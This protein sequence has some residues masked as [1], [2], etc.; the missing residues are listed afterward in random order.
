MQR[1][2][3]AVLPRGLRQSAAVVAFATL[4]GCTTLRPVAG[5]PVDWAARDARVAAL[6]DW[7]ARGR[8]AVKSDR[9]GGQGDLLWRQTGPAARLRVSGPFGAGAYE[10]RWDPQALRVTSRNGEFMREWQDAAAAEAFLGEQLGW[11]L[12][13]ASA[14]WWLL[15]LAD[16]AT[17]AS[18]EF[19]PRGELARLE[20]GGWII[21]YER[22]DATAGLEMPVRLTLQSPRARLRVVIDR[23]CL[24]PACLEGPSAASP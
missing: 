1:R 7:Q 20:Q 11:P 8:I 17:P 3:R 10:I 9:G 22:Y 2:H 14:R 12:P 4:A 21:S 6:A 24:E 5:P 16:P 15:G 23:W 13:A 19:T 18:R